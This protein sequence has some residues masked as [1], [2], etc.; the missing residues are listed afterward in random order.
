VEALAK[1][2]TLLL[3]AGLAALQQL[4]DGGPGGGRVYKSKTRHVS[5]PVLFPA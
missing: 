4:L 1:L 5:L 3:V 2:L